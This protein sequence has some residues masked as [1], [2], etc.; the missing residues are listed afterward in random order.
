M[1]EIKSFESKNLPHRIPFS[2]YPKKILLMAI[3]LGSKKEERK[4]KKLIVK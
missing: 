4:E 2:L 1:C 3:R